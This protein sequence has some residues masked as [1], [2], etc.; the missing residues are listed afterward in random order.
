[1]SIGRIRSR[2][3]DCVCL[4]IGSLTRSVSMKM[5]RFASERTDVQMSSWEKEKI[6]GRNSVIEREVDDW[7][8]KIDVSGR[9]TKMRDQRPRT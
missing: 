1:M 6:R 5:F 8:E 7:N 3:F 2:S 4:S 9:R